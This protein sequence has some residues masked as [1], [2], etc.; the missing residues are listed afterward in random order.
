[1]FKEESK[2]PA[3]PAQSQTERDGRDARHGC[4]LRCVEVF[5]D[6]KG[7][8]LLMDLGEEPPRPSQ[9]QAVQDR[10]GVLVQVR[11]GCGICEAYTECPAAL[12]API[13]VQHDVP[14]DAKDPCSDILMGPR[15][16]LEAAPHDKEGVGNHVLGLVRVGAALNKS[17]Q[18]RVDR[19]IQKSEGVLRI[20][21]MRK[22][23]H[24]LYLPA[25]RPSASQKRTRRA[26]SCL[27][28]LPAPVAAPWH[29]PH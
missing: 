2:G 9:V 7:Q 10:V 8:C 19:F 13:R 12:F 28:Q 26:A 18:V 11:Q 17:D 3:G 4:C 14:G 25:T 5:E 24:A 22:V 15:Q 6:S 20:R 21:S 16:L 23:P 1:M 27:H 29:A